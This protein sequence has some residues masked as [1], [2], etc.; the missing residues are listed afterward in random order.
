MPELVMRDEDV[1]ALLE[2]LAIR[3]D[4]PARD[5]GI[6]KVLSDAQAER[7]L[8]G[9]RRLHVWL[10]R[11]QIEWLRGALDDYLRSVHLDPSARRTFSRAL[12]R[13]CED[14]TVPNSSALDRFFGYAKIYTTDAAGLSRAEEFLKFKLQAATHAHTGL[15]EIL[16]RGVTTF[17]R[18]KD[19]ATGHPLAL[20]RET[21]DLV[22]LFRLRVALD[23][24][25]FEL[26]GVDDA[27]LQAANVAFN[28]GYA[29]NDAKLRAKTLQLA[30]TAMLGGVG[31]GGSTGFEAWAD[32]AA[33]GAAW[34]P[35]LRELRRQATHRH[36]VNTREAKPWAGQALAAPLEPAQLT[37]HFYVDLGDNHEEALGDFARRCAQGIR[38]LVDASCRQFSNLLRLLIPFHGGPIAAARRRTW[39]SAAALCAH[40]VVEPR[41]DADGVELH[42][43]FCSHC[44]VRIQ[45][46]SHLQSS[47]GST[48][49]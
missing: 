3:P 29:V 43:Y 42:P 11:E 13:L 31:A 46:A 5:G 6:R 39:A 30:L 44:G 49:L 27:L 32:P 10:N 40:Q 38:D 26:I 7:P 19:P 15:L 8:F 37:S 18:V 23:L 45:G 16:T 34:L 4:P 12:T 21:R 48:Y 28:C 22:E 1:G 41:L 35:A 20:T 25:L 33:H 36:L 14:D 2:L 24:L 17:Q 9:A 47:D